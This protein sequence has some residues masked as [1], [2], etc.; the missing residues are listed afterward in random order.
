MALAS[1]LA[2]EI[3]DVKGDDGDQVMDEA[4]V[5]A[6]TSQENGAPDVI[7]YKKDLVHRALSR[8]HR[9]TGHCGNRRPCA[10]LKQAHAQ[11]YSNSPAMFPD[12]PSTA[13]KYG[14]G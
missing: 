2:G 13:G 4:G 3:S 14:V 10:I 7:R 9:N 5:P 1:H 12:S 8:L 11:D 6:E